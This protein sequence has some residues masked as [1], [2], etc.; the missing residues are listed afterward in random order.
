M[1]NVEIKRRGQ[2]DA[3]VRDVLRNGPQLDRRAFF[4]S[5]GAFAAAAAP[6]AALAQ[7]AP[8]PTPA[9]PAPAAPARR[10]L[11]KPDERLL[12][13]GATVRSGRYW[14]FSTWM[15]P[16][17]E[18]YIR[19]HYATPTAAE[20][21]EL[22]REAWKMRIHGDSV[23]RPMEITYNDLMKMPARTIAANMQCH[24]NARNLFWENQGYSPKEVTGGSWVMGA[25][26]LAEW[27]YVPLSH[28][29]D[30]V[31]LKKDARTAL[32]WSGIDGG[33]MGR[34]MPVSEILARSDDIG[35]CFQMNGNDLLPDH[36]APVRLVVPG[37]GGTAS[38]KWLTEMR[39]TNKRVWCRLNTKG[40]VYIGEAYARP[41]VGADDE[42][43]G[44]TAEDV[45]GPMV[46]WMPPQSTL[47]V[48]LVLDKSPNMPANYPLQRGQLPMLAVGP[49]T[50]RGYAWGP[51]Y[52]VRDVEYRING[53]SW[54]PAR[55]LPPNLGRYTWVR[56]EF[57]WDAPAGEHVIETRTTDGSGYVQPA[58]QPAN[59][60]GMANGSIPSFRI[61]VA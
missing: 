61:R 3:L 1:S 39:V 51:Q 14:D 36:G 5:A 44:V 33:D 2:E 20:K 21:P 53:G 23:E 42:F 43:I 54:Q 6:A 18:F 48:P 46:T 11:R 17:E 27:R 45:K 4:V 30:R 57:P 25:I 47:T 24:G 40:E 16:V 50:M 28:I 26:G 55:I 15:T 52:G 38:I 34:P 10:I 19:N 31:G 41:E 60:L 29:L 22:A 58:T 32:F 8:A 59:L 7:G 49:Q 13:I 35:I 56:F 9:A 37:W 12:N